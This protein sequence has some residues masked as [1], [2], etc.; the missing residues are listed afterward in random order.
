LYEK[1]KHFLKSIPL[2][3]N[4]IQWLLENDKITTDLKELVKCLQ[5]IIDSKELAEKVSPPLNVAI[6]SFSFKR[7]IPP[8]HTGNGGG[9]VFDC[10]ALP[11]PGRLEQYKNLTGNEK[12]VIDFL[13]KTPETEVFLN[14]TWE[15]VKKSVENYIDRGFTN[16][17]INFGCTG[18][19]HRSVYCANQIAQKL[20]QF[21]G[22][23]ISLRHVEQE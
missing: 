15:L 16:L 2:A 9:F 18:G 13:A 10:R 3:I 1:K 21:D 20:Y 8:D 22:I 19:R 23:N 11:N 14:N 7:G 12:E 17:Q 5:L 6:N 4:N